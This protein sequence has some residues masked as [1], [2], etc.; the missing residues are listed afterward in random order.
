VH[1]SIDVNN[2][3]RPS[4]WARQPTAFFDPARINMDGT[5]VPT[6]AECKQAIDIVVIRSA[7]RMPSKATGSVRDFGIRRAFCLFF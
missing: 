4:V 2:S 1:T 6:N 7:A 5:L 3:V